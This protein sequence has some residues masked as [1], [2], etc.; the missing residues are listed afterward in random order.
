MLTPHH[1]ALFEASYSALL[2][3]SDPG[4]RLRPAT[5]APTPPADQ[6]RPKPDSNLRGS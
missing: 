5:A 3:R 4:D 6:P 2:L 1:R